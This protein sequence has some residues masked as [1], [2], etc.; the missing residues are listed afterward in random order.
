LHV[1]RLAVA[2]FSLRQQESKDG[3]TW[4]RFGGWENVVLPTQ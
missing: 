1:K 4:C 3:R 2:Q